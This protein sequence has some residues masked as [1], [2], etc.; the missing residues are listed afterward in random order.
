ML[1]TD[2]DTSITVK[3]ITAM[4]TLGVPYPEGYED[5]VMVD[6]NKQSYAI[7]TRIVNDLSEE[8]SEEKILELSKKEIVALISYLQRLGTDISKMKTE[9]EPNTEE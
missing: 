5:S 6:L 1:E 9:D 3:N 2:L 8:P 7:A 4:R